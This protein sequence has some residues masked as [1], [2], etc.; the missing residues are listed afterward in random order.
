MDEIKTK[1]KQ[2]REYIDEQEGMKL[3]DF[4]VK[5]ILDQFKKVDKMIEVYE[6]YEQWNGYRSD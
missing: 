6:D 2:I 4:K 5:W 1:L 3:H